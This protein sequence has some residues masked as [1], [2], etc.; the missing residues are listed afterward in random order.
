M[1][2]ILA[3]FR[4]IIRTFM[5]HTVCRYALSILATYPANMIPIH[6]ATFRRLGYLYEEYG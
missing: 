1:E 4:A 3:V 5:Y 6:L 2:K